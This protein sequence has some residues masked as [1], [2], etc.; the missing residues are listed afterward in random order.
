MRQLGALT[1]ALT[2]A[3]LERVLLLSTACS[4]YCLELVCMVVS[5]AAVELTR[6]C[7]RRAH[8]RLQVLETS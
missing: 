4:H 8:L 1:W 2:S 3:L 7:V 5:V 6:S